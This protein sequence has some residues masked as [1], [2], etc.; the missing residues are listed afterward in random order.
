MLL[1]MDN[2]TILSDDLMT[3][4]GTGSGATLLLK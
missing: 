4:C 2:W 1:V 3:I